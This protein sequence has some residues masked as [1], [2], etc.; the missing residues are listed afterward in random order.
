MQK[1]LIAEPTV[2]FAAALTEA[3]S[4][5]YEITCCHCGEAALQLLQEIRPQALVIDLSLPHMDGLQVLHRSSYKPP[6]V[7]ALI[8]L[9]TDYALQMAKDAGASFALL[10]PCT[11]QSVVYHLQE[12]TRRLEQPQVVIDPQQLTEKLLQDLGIPV[13]QAGF[14]QLR[15]GVPLFA[16]DESQ[17]LKKELYSAIAAVCGN[18]SSEQVER[19]IRDAVHKAWKNRNPGVWEEHFPGATKAP[20]NKVFIAVLARKLR[21]T[22]SDRI[23]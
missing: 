23:W 7:L 3:L 21:Q 1:L 10:T 8:N 15:V 2:V 22:V 18:S 6:V 13:H 12:M 5:I 17:P 16:Q 19:S 14:Y 20:S 11:T 9:A 4:E